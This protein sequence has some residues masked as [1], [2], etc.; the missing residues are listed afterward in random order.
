MF[1]SMRKFAPGLIFLGTGHVKLFVAAVN[2]RSCYEEHEL[3][4]VHVAC[5]I[6]W[7]NPLSYITRAILINEFTAGECF[8]LQ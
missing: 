5:R 8:T 4:G 6:Y 2:L 1:L 3:Y 7:A